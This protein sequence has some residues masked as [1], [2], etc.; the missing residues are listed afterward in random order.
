MLLIIRQKISQK[1]LVLV[2]ALRGLFQGKFRGNWA[3][4][5]VAIDLHIVKRVYATIIYYIVVCTVCLY[6]YY[7]LQYLFLQTLN[8]ALSRPDNKL[9]ALEGSFVE[10]RTVKK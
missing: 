3:K 9:H 10:H 5:G 7:T 8:D 4:M 6:F 2:K 1:V